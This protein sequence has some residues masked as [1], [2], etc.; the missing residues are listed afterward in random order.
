MRAL[1]LLLFVLA[2]A[3]PASAF[4]GSGRYAGTIAP[5]GCTTG[6]ATYNVACQSMMSPGLT[7]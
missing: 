3:T 5:G 4:P 1:G 7:V 2:M 6:Q